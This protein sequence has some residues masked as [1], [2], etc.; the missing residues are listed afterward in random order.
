M[1]SG[2]PGH[3]SLEGPVEALETRPHIVGHSL[4]H[5][6]VVVVHDLN[7]TS[8]RE[9]LPV[10]GAD[11]VR[12]LEVLSTDERHPYPDRKELWPEYTGVP[13][14]PALRHDVV[15]LREGPLAYDLGPIR[16]TRLFEEDE[17]VCMMRVPRRID[18]PEANADR[19]PKTK[20]VIGF[21]HGQISGAGG[22]RH[23]HYFGVFGPVRHPMSTI[24]ELGAYA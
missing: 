16:P 23:S 11:L 6:G 17:R 5:T 1:T 14:D 9:L 15:E 4:G 18:V 20:D 12:H 7:G 3:I 19:M 2:L 24:P 8:A 10:F 13:A 21:D 22:R